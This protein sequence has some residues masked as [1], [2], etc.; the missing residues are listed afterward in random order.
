VKK[1]EI[2]TVETTNSTMNKR[3]RRQAGFDEF[4]TNDFLYDYY[5]WVC[6]ETD[7]QLCNVL[8]AE[9]CDPSINVNC[10]LPDS[11]LN[12]PCL[13]GGTCITSRTIDGKQPDFI[14]VCLPGFTGKYCQLTNDFMLPPP[15]VPGPPGPPG[16][17]GP[18]G[19]GFPGGM[20]YGQPQPGGMVGYGPQQPPQMFRPPQQPLMFIPQP[21]TYGMP[22]VQ[23]PPSYGMQVQQAP[24]PPSS[25]G[26]Q[27]QQA[28][29]PPSSYGMQ[30]QQAPP[31]T[32]PPQQPLYGSGAQIRSLSAKGTDWE[33]FD[34]NCQGKGFCAQVG[35][36]ETSE[37]EFF[38]ICNDN[39][40]GSRCDEGF[41]NPCADTTLAAKYAP[42]DRRIPGYYFVECKTNSPYV[43][44]CENNK[45]FNP[46]VN[47]CQA[48]KTKAPENPTTQATSAPARQ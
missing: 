38:C 45:R 14:C 27:V 15:V 33:G 34:C 21:P 47:R 13:S 31:P 19:S 22:P 23:Q 5:D 43:R 17:Q 30:V 20:G 44:K 40:Y 7:C 46:A 6:S 39:T 29:P 8:T 4:Y 36:E 25:Y 42:I 1:P 24:P 11:C 26:M 41:R 9:C 12:N 10:M 37:P 2:K 3:N 32:Q 18:Q 48:V 35:T 16:P 28:P